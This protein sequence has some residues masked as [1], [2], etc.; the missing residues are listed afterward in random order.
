MKQKS[1][2]GMPPPTSRADFEH[3]VFLLIDEMERHKEDE[4]FLAN[5]LWALGDS[6]EHARYLPNRR[7]ELPSIDE[8]MR[9]LSNMMDWMKYLPPVSLR[10]EGE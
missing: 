10:K 9:N 3:N 8:R 2:Y 1:K 4:K 5:R 7:I 6:L